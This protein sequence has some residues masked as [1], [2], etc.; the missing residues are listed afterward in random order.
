VS[1]KVLLVVED[2]AE[3]ADAFRRLMSPEDAE[4]LRAGDAAEARRL[5]QTSGVDA[6]FLDVVFD[7]TPPEKLCGDPSRSRPAEHL[8]RQQGFYLAAELAS[9]LAPLARVVIAYDFAGEPGR[10][11]ALRERIPS[12]EGVEEGA[13]LSRVLERL[14]T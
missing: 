1:A 3:Y 2:G 12:L 11:A 10:L 7:R 5:L 9:L 4:L 8:A 13:P 6:V 14:L